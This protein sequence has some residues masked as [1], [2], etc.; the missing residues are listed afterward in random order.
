MLVIKPEDLFIKSYFVS[1]KYWVSAHYRDNYSPT[2]H[3]GL[4]NQ[5]IKLSHFLRITNLV[6]VFLNVIDITTVA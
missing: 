6:R 5:Q 4:N 1:L 3:V 2:Y